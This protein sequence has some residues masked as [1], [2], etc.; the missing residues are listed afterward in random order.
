MKSF[1]STLTLVSLV[2]LTATLS[3]QN[4]VGLLNYQPEKS[5]EGYNLFFPHN[6]STT[7]LMDNCGNIVH[8]WTLAEDLRPGNS[9]YLLEN[10]H[11][12][13]C[14]RPN[15]ITNDAIWAGGGGQYVDV[16]DWNNEILH[17]FELNDSI[18]RLH[19]DVAPMPNGNILMIA[20]EKKNYEQ[21]I[22]AGRNPA[23]L[24]NEE[25]WSE[26]ILE[27]SPSLDSIVW[28]W[29]VWDHLVQ[30]FDPT[31]DNFGTVNGNYSKIDINYDEH[32]GHPDWLHINAIHYNPV[33]DQIAL[34][35][36]YFN[37]VWI[38]DHS[39]TTDEAKTSQ[40]GAFG[41]GGDLLYRWGNPKTYLKD[42]ETTQEL[43][44]EHDVH[45]L[46]PNA[47]PEDADFGKILLF[48]NKYNQ[49]FSVGTLFQSPINW[50]EKTYIFGQGPAFLP[51]GPEKTIQHPED[52]P[53]DASD[54]LSSIQLLDN[55][56]WLI[57]FGRWGYG[58][59]LTPDNEIVWEYVVPLKAGQAVTQ[60]TQLASN[61]NLTF[62]MTRLPLD[63]P[64]F[65]DKELNDG[66]PLEINPNNLF[67]LNTDVD[68]PQLP[69]YKGFEIYPNPSSGFFTLRNLGKEPI[70]FLEVFGIDGTLKK[71]WLKVQDSD[72]FDVSTLQ[73][74]FYLIK[75]NLGIS[76]L[77]IN[78]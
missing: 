40:G 55:G 41:K 61:N 10:G 17:R 16:V 50:A 21:A 63:Y 46:N 44:F 1:I 45:W 36:P 28:K 38:I 67:C 19:H 77:I 24:P 4:T 43:F 48:N 76:P 23:L 18:F 68:Q 29:E 66:T 3:A 42:I 53:K 14:S 25:V 52:S 75:T 62:R 78:H 69:A 15:N 51:E 39:T 49:N 59:E 54:G 26:T 31:K 58:V 9:V 57:F 60:G 35:V 13:R 47:Q 6:Q 65:Q 2:F 70:H 37:E 20:W 73:N 72:S 27:W 22:A 56:N 11:L 7:F 71:Q 32:D 8:T 34:S 5:Q 30:N 74:G 33:L 64:A 12:I